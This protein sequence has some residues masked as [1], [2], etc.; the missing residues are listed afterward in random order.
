MRFWRQQIA[1]PLILLLA[2]CA[3]ST[4]EA[5]QITLA[6]FSPTA[7][8][9]DFEGMGTGSAFSTPLLFAGNTYDANGGLLDHSSKLGPVIGR[10]GVAISSRTAATGGPPAFIDIAF[11]D[12][13]LRAGIYVG[14]QFAWA[15]DVHF[16]DV[17]NALVG[18]IHL[19][20]NGEDSHFAA[21]QADGGWIKR[22]QVINTANE[23]RI[24]VD[25]LIQEVAEPASGVLVFSAIVG[26]LPYRCRASLVFPLA[27]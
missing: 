10:S 13:A 11:S 16:F 25:D 21:W 24:V 22:I 15:A 9:Q 18:T 19:T 1:S 2:I 20:G 17:T 23:N 6:D 4:A 8:V 12:A 7:I 14:E 26:L 27:Y 5:G 3:G